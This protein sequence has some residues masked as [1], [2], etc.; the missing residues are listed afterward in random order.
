M[1]NSR[2]R[3]AQPRVGRMDR[4]KGGDVHG[5]RRGDESMRERRGA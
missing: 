2:V 1:W 4:N 3:R 5:E